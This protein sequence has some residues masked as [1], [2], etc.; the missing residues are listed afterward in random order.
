MDVID[1]KKQEKKKKN[2][3]SIHTD[4]FEIVN[5]N[6]C[7]LELSVPTVSN[8]W[9]P[10]SNT[11]HFLESCTGEKRNNTHTHTQQ[12]RYNGERERERERMKGMLYMI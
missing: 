4:G 1:S 10:T 12:N 7:A 3:D 9:I 2:D 8:G 5:G 6:T 11:T